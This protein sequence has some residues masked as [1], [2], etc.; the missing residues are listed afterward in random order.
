MSDTSQP[1]TAELFR[2]DMIRTGIMSQRQVSS[3]S[4]LERQAPAQLRM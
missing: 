4:A 2:A 1:G 3:W